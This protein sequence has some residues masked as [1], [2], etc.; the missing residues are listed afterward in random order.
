ML[1]FRNICVSAVADSRETLGVEGGALSPGAPH[2]CMP[3]WY[4]K[5]DQVPSRVPSSG[6]IGK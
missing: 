4:I 3:L 2:V 6:E 5:H 1:S